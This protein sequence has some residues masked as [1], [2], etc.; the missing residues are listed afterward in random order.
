MQ[1]IGERII[2]K[3]PQEHSGAHLAGRESIGRRTIR[4][5][6]ILTQLLAADPTNYKLQQAIV[7]ELAAS[8]QAKLAV[9]II[10][11]LVQNNPGDPQ[12]LR[13]GWQVYLAAQEYER[14]LTVGQEL[15]RVDTAAADTT[16]YIRTAGVYSALNRPAD[17]AAT[18]QAG[19]QKFP[20]NATLSLAGIQGL[21][22]SGKM[23]EA[24]AAARR[25]LATDPKNTNANVLLIQALTN[26]DEISRRS[27]VRS[28]PAP[29]PAFSR[30]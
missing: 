22:K 2:A 17:V 16:Y 21:I 28:L 11:D 30:S 10:T 14:A 24:A 12:I 26:P 1:A 6:K 7:N 15:I 8:G 3:D 4:A 23:A 25:I 9:P 20:N 5:V 19:A 29:I 13:T 27:T 18:L